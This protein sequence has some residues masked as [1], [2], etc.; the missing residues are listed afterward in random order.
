[1]RSVQEY[2]DQTWNDYRWLWLS[3]D[4][5]AFHFGYHGQSIRTH[6]EA[7][8]NTNRVLAELASIGAGSVVLDAGCG[9]GGSSQWFAR[10]LGARA[11]GITLVRSQAVRAARSARLAGLQSS[12]AV[13]QG[14]YTNAPLRS[15]A[16]DAV[17]A[18]ESLCHAADKPSFYREAARLLKPGGRLVV[19]EYMR[20]RRHLGAAG[21]T[22][23]RQW[24]DGW[25]IPDLDTPE[26]HGSHAT[27]AGLATVEVRDFT[28]LVTPS[29]HRLH[30]LA[31]ATYPL[32]WLA[33][34]LHMR[35]D[36]QHGNVVA[37]IRQYEALQGGYWAYGV[38]TAAKPGR[39]GG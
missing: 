9:V 24:L 18:L 4:D 2:Y 3:R 13:L 14:D 32:A 11:V 30:R 5:L 39:S 6:R 20:T 35:S 15:G 26:E 21:E 7:L 8:L 38:L 10:A 22:T 12:V 37:A 28:S 1:M 34:R 33:R 27:D 17:V 25:V 31:S 16:F 29:L 19:A 23:V 36:V